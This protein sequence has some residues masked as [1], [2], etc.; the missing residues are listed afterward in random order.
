MSVG[1]QLFRSYVC[2]HLGYVEQTVMTTD[3]HQLNVRRLG[4]SSVNQNGG[5]LKICLLSLSSHLY[6]TAL[7][8]VKKDWNVM[9]MTVNK[10]ECTI[11]CHDHFYCEDNFCKPRC[12][13]FREYSDEYVMLSDGLMITSGSLGLVCTIAVLVLF[14]I[15]RKTLMMFP[16]I[17]V[18][19]STIS[20][21]FV[22]VIV[23]V[24][25]MGRPALFCSSI[26]LVYSLQNSAPFCKLG[27]IVQSF[28]YLQVTL[29]WL[30]NIFALY[31]KIQFPFHARYYDTTKRT[32]VYTYC[33]CNPG[34]CGS[35]I[36]PNNNLCQ[37][38]IYNDQVSP[39]CLP[40]KRS[41]CKL[42]YYCV[43]NYNT[44]CCWTNG[45]VADSLENKKAHEPSP[46]NIRVC[47]THNNPHSSR[48]KNF[49][50]SSLLYFLCST[51][52]NDIFTVYKEYQ[53]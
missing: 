11:Q 4:T 49:H 44:L 39:Y 41:R 16:T 33:L 22:E 17:L 38:W 42:L 32:K 7:V 47:T 19:Y 26:D 45:D 36:C 53:S 15:R 51:T 13:R 9:V 12:D 24:S 29:L 30:L 6:L 43:S 2:T 10:T 23:L 1:V 50:S 46:Q 28:F 48:T 35:N 20:L 52:A 27:G 21:V 37:W 31:W 34:L 14:F 3:P 40:W 18:F 25:F 5:E 8:S